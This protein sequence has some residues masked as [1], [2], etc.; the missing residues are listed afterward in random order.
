MS[1]ASSRERYEFWQRHMVAWQGSGLSG[2]SFCKQ[3]ELN[4]AQFNY[5]RKKLVASAPE[6]K[7]AGFARVTQLATSS[8]QDG[9]ALHLPSGMRLSG[10]TGSSHLRV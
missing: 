1:S 2:A 8:V 4:Y 6:S 10:I 5:W 7:P 9:L 3:H